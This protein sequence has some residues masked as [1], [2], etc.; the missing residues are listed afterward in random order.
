MIYTLTL[1][2]AL[3][4]VMRLNSL[5]FDDVNRAYSAKMFYGGKGI[6]VTAMLTR[7]GLESVGLG[8]TAGYTGEEFKRMLVAEGV[9]ID[10]IDLE[11]GET[12]IN[13]KLRY[14]S[15]LDVNAEGPVVSDGEV[16]A[17]L[18][19][20][21]AA[22]PG[23]MVVLSGSIPSNLPDDFYETIIKRLE[24]RGVEFVCD[25]T[26]D[27]LLN[28]LKYRPFLV[29]PNHHELGDLF[30]VSADTED[31]VI[32]YAFKLREMGALNVLVSRSENGAVL[33][34]ETGSV[35]TVGV[36]KGEYVNSVGCGDSMVAGFIAGYK[37]TGDYEYALRLG[38]A[39]GSATAFSEALGSVE[40]IRRIFERINN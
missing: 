40:M 4:Y 11:K 2:P 21:D 18:A 10:F 33:I 36:V 8:F 26:G 25:A 15:D 14:G 37:K 28:V 34:D 35:H 7:L 9:P 6:N 29:K 31:K 22:G 19:K 3:D 17:L 38:A 23:D 27:L 16:D 39:C 5:R 13:V 12:R 30:G 1:N 24:G 32:E 20:L